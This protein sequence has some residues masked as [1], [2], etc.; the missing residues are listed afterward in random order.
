MTDE[1][2]VADAHEYA[3]QVM[4]NVGLDKAEYLDGL[5]VADYVAWAHSLVFQ[6]G[7]QLIISLM[8]TGGAPDRVWEV[9]MASLSNQAAV[10]AISPELKAEAVRQACAVAAR[11]DQPTEG[12]VN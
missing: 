1:E 12:V 9:F 6:L 2:L 4:R 5:D 3:R 8:S 11:I 7:R 10:H